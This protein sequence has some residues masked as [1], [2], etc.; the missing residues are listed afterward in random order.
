MPIAP[1]EVVPISD[2]HIARRVAEFMQ[3]VDNHLST[4][5][6]QPKYEFNPPHDLFASTTVQSFFQ[7]S[8][9]V[10]GWHVYYRKHFTG[11]SQVTL[12]PRLTQQAAS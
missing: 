3:V 12:I 6:G 4:K 1:N 9:W 2:P 11:I 5:P 8:Y 7:T 10:V